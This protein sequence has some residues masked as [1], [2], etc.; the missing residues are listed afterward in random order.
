MQRVGVLAD[1]EPRVRTQERGVGWRGALL[2]T[3]PAPSKLGMGST[4]VW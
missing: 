2:R 3:S 1:G 4:T